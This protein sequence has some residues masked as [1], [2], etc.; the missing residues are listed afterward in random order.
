MR[1][2][3]LATDYDGTIAEHGIVSER[4]L[5]ALRRLKE[6]KRRLVLVT[7]REL[8][9]LCRVFPQCELFDAIVVE[10]GAVF[11]DP[12]NRETIVLAPRPPAALVRTLGER[13]VPVSVGR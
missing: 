9:D 10:N 3:A 12:S 8:D 6:S 2:H 4:C 5:D 13:G 7:G 1:Y 11:F